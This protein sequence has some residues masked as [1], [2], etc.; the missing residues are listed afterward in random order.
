MPITVDKSSSIE[1]SIVYC[2]QV[3]AYINGA[4]V[5]IRSLVYDT[6]DQFQAD[7][8]PIIQ[9]VKS[10]TDPSTVAQIYAQYDS[11]YDTAIRIAEEYL[12]ANDPWYQGGSIL[13]P[14]KGVGG[15]QREG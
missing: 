4:Q 1:G 2:V 13:A 7:F 6:I 10:I 15:T 14:G 8:L 9:K 3:I 12:I 11:N 5:V